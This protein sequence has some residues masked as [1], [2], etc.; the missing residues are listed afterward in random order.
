MSEKTEIVFQRTW[1]R[2]ETIESELGKTL[3]DGFTREDYIALF[4]KFSSGVVMSFVVNKAS[5]VK[6]INW[7]VEH[8]QLGVDTLE[9][10]NQIR[11]E[12]ISFDDR[13]SREYFKSFDALREAVE[14][15]ILMAECA[16]DTRFDTVVAAMYLSWFG[17]KPEDACNIEKDGLTAAGVMV[18]GKTVFIPDSVLDFLKEYS[19]AEGFQQQARGLIT[20]KYVPSKYL[21]RTSKADHLD[22]KTLRTMITRFSQ[23]CDGGIKFQLDKIY[24]SG[25]YS[26]AYAYECT[27]GLLKP[28]DFKTLES[29]FNETYGDKFVANKRLRSYQSYRDFYHKA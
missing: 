22:V 7:L 19:E 10:L 15:T 29:V 23:I 21:L 24:W 16:D 13:Y 4:S 14:D 12:D 27:N 17:I 26:R 6:F 28:F 11:Y 25:I 3:E 5:V 18:N 2:I 8:D 20:H 9:T 1:R